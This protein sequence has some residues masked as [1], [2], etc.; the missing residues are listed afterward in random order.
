VDATCGSGSAIR[1]STQT[2]T[3]T[4]QWWRDESPRHPPRASDRAPGQPGARLAGSLCPRPR[5][6]SCPHPRP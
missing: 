5:I 3:E 1:N 4:A 6:R 2:D